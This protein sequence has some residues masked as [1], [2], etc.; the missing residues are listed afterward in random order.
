MVL[1]TIIKPKVFFDVNNKKDIERFRL[2][3]EKL[4][5]GHDGCPYIL[6]FPYLTIPDMIRDKLI[7]KI[8]KVEKNEGRNQ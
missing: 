3:L 1:D 7:H 5:W 2:F 4:A 6:E 8:L